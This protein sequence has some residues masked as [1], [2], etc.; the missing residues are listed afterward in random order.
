MDKI[1]TVL[2]HVSTLDTLN[3]WIFDRI[4]PFIGKRVLE[5][6]CGNG[7]LTGFYL[8]HADLVVA[9]DYDSKL[10]QAI[11]SRY[12][13]SHLQV[14]QEDLTGDLS[15]LNTYH[16]DTIICL[17]TLEHIEEDQKTLKNFYALLQNR[18]KLILQVP[19]FPFLY[20]SIDKVVG[21]HRRYT[22]KDLITQIENNGF[23]VTSCTYFNV[24]GTLGWFYNGKIIRRP[25]LSLSL[26][27]IFNFLLPFFKYIEKGR[28][29]PFG[30]SLI[31]IAEK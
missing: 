24:F 12:S 8:K 26:L 29:L 14:L 5:A 3:S 17:N 4:S 18:G 9:V 27:S 1:R 22:R 11:K 7:N 19:A 30:L 25:Y 20:G 21:H 6:G 15:K 28:E 23:R 2:E 13:D 31:A 10:I 16:L